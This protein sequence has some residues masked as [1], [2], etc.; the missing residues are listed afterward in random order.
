M[1]RRRFQNRIAESVFTL[2]VCS[3]LAL[4]M[5]WWPQGSFS[6]DYLLGLLCCAF[7]AY[8]IL[9][10]NN[11]NSLI[12]IRTR[13]VSCLWVICVAGMGFLH[14]IGAPLI[15]AMFL[16]I[17]YSQLCRTYQ[18][19]DA[20]VQAFHANLFLA[21]GSLA[22]PPM[23]LFSLLYIVYFTVYMRCMDMRMLFACVVALL[24]P[25]WLWFGWCV[26]NQDFSPLLS[27]LSDV[28]R[29]QLPTVESYTGIPLP[30]LSAW[31]LIALLSV[32]GTVHYL[33]NRYD[34]KIKVR[35]LLYVFVCQ[36]VFLHVLMLLQPQYVSVVL[37]MLMVSCM[38]LVAHYFALTYSWVSNMFFFVAILLITA[39]SV[40][41]LWVR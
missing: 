20:V 9:E 17:S 5:W 6:I 10:T 7:T 37:P 18:C 22:F 2:P 13:L 8:V 34:D 25:Y 21:L 39:V 29:F 15:A 31:A 16:S 30:V 32:V 36:T 19:H 1:R 12:R 38:P 40:V 27:H 35:M 28:V 26:W 23:I 14:P 41:N 24:L 3:V 33:R 4:V 11:A